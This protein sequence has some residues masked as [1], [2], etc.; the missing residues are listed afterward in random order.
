MANDSFEIETSDNPLA[1]IR[2]AHQASLELA[3]TLSSERS[4][5]LRLMA[6]ALSDCRSDIL[7]A[8]TLDL[9]A[10]RDMAV[11]DLLLEWLKLTPE[12]VQGAINILHC[13]SDLPDPIRRV[14]NAPFQVEQAQTY[15]QLMPLGAI[16]LIYEAIPELGAIA[17]GMCLKTGNS[18]VLKGSTEASHSNIAIANVLQEA[19]AESQLPDHCLELLPSDT[20][21]SVRE[22]VSQDR[23]LSLIIP[24]GRESLVQPIIEKAT[25]PVLRSA[26]GNC[27]L[28]WSPSGSLDL[29]RSIINDSH[30]SDPDPVNAI[31]KVLIHP[32]QKPSSL[33]SL[34]NGLRDKGFEIRGDEALVEEFPDLELAQPDEW[35]QAY[36]T[37][38]IAFKKVESLQEGMLWINQYSSGHADCLVTES[39]HE[40][41]QFSLG[42]KSA[43]VY[44][45]ISPRFSRLPKP[46][47]TVYLGM[48]N[49]SG[50]YRGFINLE[51][52]TRI[53]HVI[54]GHE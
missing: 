13:L 42:V 43:S 9:E 16:A 33:L 49:R 45:N 39:Y 1:A 14:I 4:Q 18:L 19:L 36:L 5:A 21:T 32:E 3:Q 29:V 31:E 20:G 50:Y 47:H 41:C 22:L 30:Q 53:K 23:H 52:L 37:K 44:I 24:H 10:S 38:T 34:W 2:R 51:A 54:Q 48:S 12:R 28:Y 17:A 35:R 15:C 25:V 7:E 11:P 26:I 8:N 46:N 27:Y 6:E 40:S